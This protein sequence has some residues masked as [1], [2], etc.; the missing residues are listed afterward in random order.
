MKSSTTYLSLYLILAVIL[1]SDL[2][3]F[4][5]TRGFVTT[6]V[7]IHIPDTDMK[8]PVLYTKPRF[9]NPYKRN[10][11]AVFRLFPVVLKWRPTTQN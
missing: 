7:E 8:V 3:L 10:G 5:L 11:T 2:L 1:V 6:K 4:F 9:I